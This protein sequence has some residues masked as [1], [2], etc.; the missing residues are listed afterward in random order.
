MITLRIDYQSYTF[1]SA[2]RE[3]KPIKII[4]INMKKLF[5]IFICLFSIS[6]TAHAQRETRVET[7]F[8]FEVSGKPVEVTSPVAVTPTETQNV[9]RAANSSRPGVSIPVHVYY[10][11]HYTGGWDYQY[12]G[13]LN[14]SGFATL[15]DIIDFLLDIWHLL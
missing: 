5:F 2:I 1:H 7:K 3:G 13:T 14:V 15:G 4:I 6:L 10:Y 11:N 9:L 12:S 8:V